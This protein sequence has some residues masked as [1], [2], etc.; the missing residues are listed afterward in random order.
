MRASPQP[1]KG[2]G[3]NAGQIGASSLGSFVTDSHR[4]RPVSGWHGGK[5]GEFSTT[6]TTGSYYGFHHLKVEKQDGVATY[7]LYYKA[8]KNFIAVVRG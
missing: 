5:T 1:G 2:N 3:L 7:S 6:R 8:N 4:D